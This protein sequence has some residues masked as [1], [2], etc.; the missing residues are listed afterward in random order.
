MS[1]TQVKITLENAKEFRVI[2]KEKV[3]FIEKT[4]QNVFDWYRE[5]FSDWF[6]SYPGYSMWTLDNYRVVTG[7]VLEYLEASVQKDFDLP[8]KNV[9][10]FCDLVNKERL[11]KR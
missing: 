11:L 8:L 4:G 10:D 6:M 5:T 9:K 7:N 2:K 1:L 3:Y